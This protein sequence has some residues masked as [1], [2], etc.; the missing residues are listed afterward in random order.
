VSGVSEDLLKIPDLYDPSQ[1]HDRNP[2]SE[3]LNDSKIMSN[4]KIGQSKLF[5]QF[6][7][8]IQNLRLY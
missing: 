8:Q 7:Q 5:L 6:L 3:I 4:Q 1:I 2:I